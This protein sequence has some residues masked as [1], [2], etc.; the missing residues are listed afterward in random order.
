MKT[1]KTIATLFLLVISVA[2]FSTEPPAKS[3]NVQVLPAHPGTLKVLYVNPKAKYVDIRLCNED[4]VF[5]TDRVKVVQKG[6]IARYDVSSVSADEFWI[7]IADSDSSV[8][9]RIQQDGWGNLW[10]TYWD[11]PSV[12]SSVIAAK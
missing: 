12:E 8:K 9:Y 2:A 6:F 7:E 5:F 11:Y 1:L 10:A 4:G 3:K